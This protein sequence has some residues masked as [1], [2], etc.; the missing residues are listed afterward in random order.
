MKPRAP[1]IGARSVPTSKLPEF[2]REHER[3][4][5]AL[6]HFCVAERLTGRAD[7]VLRDGI[8]RM[9]EEL[10][11]LDFSPLTVDRDLECLRANPLDGIA[12]AIDHLNV[13]RDHV[14]GAAEDGSLRR[15]R[16]SHRQGDDPH[17]QQYGL[18]AHGASDEHR[19]RQHDGYA[20]TSKANL[21][22]TGLTL[23]IA[24]HL[25]RRR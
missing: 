1:S 23:L 13:D 21:P 5:L 22:M 4:A 11:G 25:A 18:A 14:H 24:G 20:M 16:D 3:A 10:G 15:G 12:V 9:P 19:Y 2:D 6:V 17:R 7:S 8:D